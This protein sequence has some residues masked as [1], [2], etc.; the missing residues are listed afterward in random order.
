MEDEL[1]RNQAILSALGKSAILLGLPLP[2]DIT[3]QVMCKSIYNAHGNF[4]HLELAEAIEMAAT[5]K[6]E[7]KQGNPLRIQNHGRLSIEY[8]SEC[9]SNY[10]R[11][12]A[13]AMKAFLAEQSRL[14]LKEP[15]RMTPS[16]SYEGL[17]KF[18][19]TN[20]I[21]P[22]YW[23]WTSAFDYM[24]EQS[25]VPGIEADKTLYEAQKAEILKRLD[26]EEKMATN[27]MMKAYII[28]QRTEGAVVTEIKRIRVENYF[29]TE[30]GIQ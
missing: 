4:T 5:W 14:Q 22:K 8:I 11:H 6:F 30:Y 29:K 20:K 10:S 9:L 2:D 12:R 18:V 28:A 15:E 19:G 16:E 3:L 27:L 17:A 26:L 1:L 25:L 13:K 23:A 24:A 7:D 21:M